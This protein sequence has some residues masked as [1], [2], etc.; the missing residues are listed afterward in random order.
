MLVLTAL[1][2]VLRMALLAGNPVPRPKVAD[3]FSYLLLGDTIAHFRLANPIHPMRRFFEGVFT[4]QEPTYSSIYPAGQGLVLAFGQ[5]VFGHP[6][7][8]VVISAA[9]ICA[10]CYWMLRAWTTPVWAL[11]GGLLAVF[12]FGPLSPWMNL[13]WGGAVSAAAGC[14]I[15]GSLPRRNAGL[16][17]LG[18]ALQ[19][20]TRPFEFLLVLFIVLLFFRRNLRPVVIAALVMLPAIGLTLLQNKQVTGSWTTL[21]YVLSRYQY[22]IPTTFTFQPNPVPHKPLTQEQ[23]IDYEAQARA[24]G[25]GTDTIGAWIERLGKRIRFYR[26]FFLAPLY[27]AIPAFLIS[28]RDPRHRWIILSLA[29]LWAGTG[30]YPYFYPHYIAAAT[31]L[32][33]L[34]SIK[35]L[36]LISR[37]N[38]EAVTLILLF[39]L[40]HFVFWYG[41]YFYGDQNLLAAAANY[42]GQY[43]TGVGDPDG[44]IAVDRQLAQSPGKQLVFVRYSAQHG[45]H[46][47]IRNVAVIDRARVVWALDLGPEEDEKLR[48]YYPD[49]NAWLLEPDSRPPK[50]SNYPD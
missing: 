41:V 7:A 34:V 39:C 33:I 12:E 6:W 20:L 40:A 48:R 5:L 49:R 19:L 4:L 25:D 18:L 22:G 42:E 32:F 38:Q 26:F 2:V 46:E 16:L 44:R 23:Q 8:G 21:P 9:A 29:M 14:L 31:C 50:L 28:F 47:W 10:L 11:A 45:G 1:P 17:G 43:S 35:G 15:F 30:F 3:D 37:V 36:E 27:L 13:Y 24:H